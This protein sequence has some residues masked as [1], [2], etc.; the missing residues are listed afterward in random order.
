MSLTIE[1]TEGCGPQFA[2]AAA[3][4]LARIEQFDPTEVKEIHDALYILRLRTGVKAI[5][6]NGDKVVATTPL[7]PEDLDESLGYLDP[8]TRIQYPAESYVDD[9]TMQKLLKAHG[10]KVTQR[11]L[12]QDAGAKWDGGPG[13]NKWYECLFAYG[14]E[15][16]EDQAYEAMDRASA[17]QPS[18]KASPGG[19]AL[20]WR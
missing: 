4:I 15:F 19:V 14:V 16:P 12:R 9:R 11:E 6:R 18:Y 13:A 17:T 1:I 2:D 8:D 5:V 7:P 3:G 20:P 10:V